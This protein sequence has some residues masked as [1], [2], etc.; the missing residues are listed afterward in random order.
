MRA[1]TVGA[2]ELAHVFNESQHRGLERRE[3][4][5]RLAGIDQSHVLRGANDDGTGQLRLGAER[6]LNVARPRRQVDQQNVK[7]APFDLSHHLLQRPHQHR[8][9]PDDGLALF[10]HETD[11]HHGDTMG[12]QRDDR[13]PVGAGGA[14][15]DAHHARLARPVN[16]GIEQPDA[17]PGAGQR[18]GK[19]GADGG[20]AHPALSGPDGDDI[21]NARRFDRALLRLG[22]PPE[23]QRRRLCR[24]GMGRQ[25]HTDLA[26][27]RHFAHH[28]FS[29][30]T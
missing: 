9:P 14:L 22:M 11:G 5:Q 13:F 18:H 19:V 29:G 2:D 28:L 21:A 24:G 23:L 20:F 25:R 1:A 30:V 12:L 15:A 27:A 17:A 7:L 10:D 16:I 4:V 26:D 3:H 8:T 6:Q